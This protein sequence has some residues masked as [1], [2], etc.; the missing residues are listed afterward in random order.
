MISVIK[1]KAIGYLKGEGGVVYNS[2]HRKKILLFLK[3]GGCT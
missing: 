2:A 3:K 1:D